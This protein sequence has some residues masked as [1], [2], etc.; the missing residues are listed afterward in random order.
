MGETD[1]RLG[2]P[3]RHCILQAL[4][5]KVGTN[6]TRARETKPLKI[7]LELGL[8]AKATAIQRTLSLDRDKRRED[9]ETTRPDM[10]KCGGLLEKSQVLARVGRGFLGAVPDVSKWCGDR[11]FQLG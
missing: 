8:G 1:S 11:P 2:L 4:G 5:A 9:L 10:A 3:P 6:S 7:Y